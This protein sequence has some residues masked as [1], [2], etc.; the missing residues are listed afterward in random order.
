MCRYVRLLCCLLVPLV[1]DTRVKAYCVCVIRVAESVLYYSYMFL[2]RP[3][4][5]R[6]TDPKPT[7]RRVLHKAPTPFHPHPTRAAPLYIASH[8]ATHGVSHNPR[9]HSTPSARASS[10]A[11]ASAQALTTGGAGAITTIRDQ[12]CST[13][14][15]SSTHTPHV[16]P[17]GP[18]H[19][20]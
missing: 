4:V 10:Q 15:S 17:E 19:W 20:S 14:H 11:R 9:A 12:V 18:P 2:V 1:G 7:H 8:H 6:S 13:Q 3:L 5:R 16:S